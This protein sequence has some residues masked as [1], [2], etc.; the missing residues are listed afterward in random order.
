MV[1]RNKGAIALVGSLSCKV[2]PFVATY[3]SEKAKLVTWAKSLQAELEQFS[4]ISVQCLTLGKVN[5]PSF[6]K[7]KDEESPRK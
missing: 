7:Y 6:N 3:A 1:A 5:T 2:G 4:D